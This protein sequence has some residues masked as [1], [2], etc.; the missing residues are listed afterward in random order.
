[1]Q[2]RELGT[3]L[4]LAA[5]SKSKLESQINEIRV[6]SSMDNDERVTRLQEELTVLVLAFSLNKRMKFNCFHLLDDDRCLMMT[7]ALQ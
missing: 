2:I 6:Q 4:A 3:E 1:M 5:E 7:G